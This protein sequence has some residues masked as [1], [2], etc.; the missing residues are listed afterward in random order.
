MADPLAELAD[1]QVPERTNYFDPA[2][3]QTVISRYAN[4]RRG[5]ES[6]GIL[7]KA[8]DDQM[9]SRNEQ[10]RADRQQVMW[11]RDDEDYQAKK[12]ALSQQGEF[13]ITLSQLDHEDPDYVNKLSE[14][15][16][17]MPPQ[18][19][20]EAAVK[21]ILTFKD[22]AADDARQR[23]N[24][25]AG[26]QQTLANQQA[27]FRE[28]AQY[29]P[30]FK[31]ITPEDYKNATLPDGSTDMRTLFTL[32]NERERA[33]KEGEFARR[34]DLLQQ[35]RIQLVKEQDLSKRGRERRGNVA[36]F[37]V[38]DRQAF[39]RAIETLAGQYASQNDGKA[40]AN[41]ELLKSNPKWSAKYLQAEAQDK[42]P[43]N[44]EL[45][46][47]FAYPDADD[48]VNLVPGISESQKDRR[49]QVWEHAHRDD[50]V[51]ERAADKEAPLS[52]EPA[53]KVRKWNPATKKL[54]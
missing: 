3:S 54:E 13:L 39:P 45:S 4:A 43:L 23:R 44:Y 6:S 52:Q 35:N 27:M 41:I 21:S 49:R 51:E 37:I 36:K 28:R 26:K 25:E 17:G 15:V 14:T 22:R 19:L 47:A 1:R 24:S 7:A 18:L 16:A 42:S 33:Y 10:A 5:A 38:E 50:A 53:P 20:E 34:Q 29:G 30:A 31:H 11:N 32:G 2:A 8:A 12:D 9:R 46:A 40:P 48:Y